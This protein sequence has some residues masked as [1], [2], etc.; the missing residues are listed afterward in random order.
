MGYNFAKIYQELR[1][2][3]PLESHQFSFWKPSILVKRDDSIHPQVSGNKWRKL[4]GFVEW[5]SDHKIRKWVSFGGPFSNHVLALSYIAHWLNIP[6]T[7]YIRG[8]QH[9]INNPTLQQVQ[10]LG[11]EIQ[12]VPR[13]SFR[14]FM[15]NF[16]VLE[17]DLMV[18]PEGGSHPLCRVG[19]ENMMDEI[20]EQVDIHSLHS[21]W[22]GCGTGGSIGGIFRVKPKKL[23]CYAVCAVKDPSIPQRIQ[24]IAGKKPDDSLEIIF[25]EKSM[26]YRKL[27]EE[28]TQF[29]RAIYHES[30]IKLDPIYTVKVFEKLN[31]YISMNDL[32]DQDKILIVHTGGLQGLSGY[33]YIHNQSIYNA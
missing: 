31:Q 6:L 23:K 12:F 8:Q 11:T 27:S 13:H 24:K 29:M 17:A 10:S 21:L 15:E 26:G 16:Q 9:F 3:S 20:S 7:C 19:I 5:A 2:P 25:P 22:I 30:G 33:T 1:L 32:G 28:S 18:I 4:K 14:H